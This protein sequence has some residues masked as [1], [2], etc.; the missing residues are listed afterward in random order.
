MKK[1]SSFLIVLLSGI[2]AASYI[3]CKKTELV[4]STTTDV[5]IY[6]YLAQNPDKF[7]ELV[8]II[9]KT[10][11]SDFLNAYG[12]YTLFAPN[13][14]AIKAYLQQTGKPSVDAFS[15][16]ELK[17]SDKATSGTGHVKYKLIQGWKTPPGNYAG[18][19]LV[20]RGYQ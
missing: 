3:S 12:A 17:K 19:V 15:V 11:Y 20:N 14:A 6:G 2:L 8:K 4:T 10:G 7:S 9:D 5:N 1:K 16:E 13:N 18:T